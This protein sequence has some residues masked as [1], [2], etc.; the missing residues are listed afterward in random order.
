MA[1]TNTLHV[2]I[3][4]RIKEKAEKTL[5][6]LGLSISEA[7]NVFLTQVVLHDGIPFEIKKPNYNR[8]TIQALDDAKKGENVSKT[9]DNADEMFKELNK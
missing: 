4:P 8:Q 9:F 7:I 1:K 6:S 2:R 3:E 5:N